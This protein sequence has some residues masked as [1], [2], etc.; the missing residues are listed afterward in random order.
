LIQL[1]GTDYVA[2]LPVGIV[3]LGLGFHLITQC[4]VT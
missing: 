2:R 4:S 1:V 3:F